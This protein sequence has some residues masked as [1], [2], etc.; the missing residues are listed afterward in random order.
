[1]NWLLVRVGA[2]GISEP[3]QGDGGVDLLP[4][5]NGTIDTPL[6]SPLSLAAALLVFAAATAFRCLTMGGRLLTSRAFA[7]GGIVRPEL[8]VLLRREP[9]SRHHRQPDLPGLA[10]VI[11]RALRVPK[12]TQ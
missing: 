8:V 1:M 2:L 6:S 9:F 10:E 4:R 12:Q 5:V 11:A 3:C 7:L